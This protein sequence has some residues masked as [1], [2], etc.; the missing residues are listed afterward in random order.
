VNYLNSFG[1]TNLGLTRSSDV[2]LELGVGNRWQF[3]NFSVGGE[4]FAIYIPL[5]VEET[6]TFDFQF[7]IM[8]M[9]VGIS[10]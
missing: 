1:K 6:K 3:K 5:I 4:W 9:Q 8:M 2:G 10:F 7:R